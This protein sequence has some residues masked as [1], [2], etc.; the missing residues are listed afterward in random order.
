MAKYTVIS[1]VSR[2]I[3]DLLKDKLVPEPVSKVENI[4]LCEPKERGSFVVGIHP[5]DIKIL[6]ELAT[7]QDVVLPDGS[8]QNPPTVYQVNYVISISSKAE[9]ASRAIDEQRILGKII[10][11]LADTP[12]LPE[13]YMPETLRVSNET[14]GVSMLKLDLEEKVKIWSM[15]SEPYKLSVFYSVGP[16]YVDS[17]IIKRPSKRVTTV[18]IRSDQMQREGE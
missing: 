4:G 3:V 18:D 12:N 2:S 13:E 6:D 15:F 10:Q 8:V 16:I 9:V 14:I 7:Q 5:Y 11:V 17:E 1:D